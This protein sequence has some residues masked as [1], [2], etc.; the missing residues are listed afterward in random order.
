MKKTNVQKSNRIKAGENSWTFD[1]SKNTFGLAKQFFGWLASLDTWQ[2][3]RMFWRCQQ[4]QQLCIAHLHINLYAW[5]CAGAS[6]LN[7]VP[8]SMHAAD[9]QYCRTGVSYLCWNFRWQIGA[10]LS[11]MAWSMSF[12]SARDVSEVT[13]STISFLKTAVLILLI[14]RNDT[15]SGRMT[16]LAMLSSQ[17]TAMWS[18]VSPWSRLVERR[19]LS[20]CLWNTRSS[21]WSC[22]WVS[23]ATDLFKLNISMISCLCCHEAQNES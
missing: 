6:Q 2:S 23:L 14:L 10:C 8:V 12:R 17:R 9:Q 5:T 15:S 20:L 16:A 19:R 13:E 7:D 3:R 4:V 1:L 11:K 18:E 21:R 22:V